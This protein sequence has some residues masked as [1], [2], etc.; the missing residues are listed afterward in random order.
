MVIVLANS[1]GGVGKSTLAVHLAVWLY[2]RGQRV[3]LVDADVQCSSSVWLQEA[4]PSVTVRNS[5]TPEEVVGVVRELQRTH[6][7]VI[8]DGQ[9]TLDDQSRTLLLLADLAILPVTPSILDVRSVQQATATLRYAQELNSGR[10]RGCL[11]LNR[12]RRRDV[13]SR[14]VRV[15]GSSLDR[16]STRLNSSH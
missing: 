7:F 4:E 3:A 5:R 10:P 13:I 1:K 2:D 6:D 15:A 12:M 8:G 9:A 16:K 11:V 14:E